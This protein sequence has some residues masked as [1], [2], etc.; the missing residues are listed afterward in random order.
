[1]NRKKIPLRGSQARKGIV[2]VNDNNGFALY[3]CSHKA[4]LRAF[5]HFEAVLW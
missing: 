1:M 3:K 2:I 4:A 5:Q